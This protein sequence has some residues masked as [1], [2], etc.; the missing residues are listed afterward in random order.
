[1]SWFDSLPEEDLDESARRIMRARERDSNRKKLFLSLV[2]I[3]IIFV[4]TILFDRDLLSKQAFEL[5]WTAIIG[6]FVGSSINIL[7]S[8]E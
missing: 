1:M 5:I 8:K 6:G 2:F 3:V 7:I 4:T